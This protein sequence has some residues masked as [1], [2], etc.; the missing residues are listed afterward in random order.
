MPAKD[1][2]HDLVRNALERE[3]WTITHD[4]LLLQV[5]GVEMSIDLGAEILIA[6]EKA[7]QK[8]A[9]EVKSFVG[10]SAINEFYGAL[11]QYLNYR[12]A[13]KEQEPE[14][15][16]FLAVPADTYDAFFTLRF[17]EETIQIYQLNLIV[18]DTNT[19]VIREWLK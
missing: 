3:G 10:L 14:R 17:I 19:E 12:K 4:P 16:L 7:G 8:I 5:G 6:A 18:Y 9:V 2:Y 11:G 13:L 1:I 15:L